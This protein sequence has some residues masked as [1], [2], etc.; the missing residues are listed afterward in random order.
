MPTG[1]RE[2]TP[3]DRELIAAY[4]KKNRAGE[5]ATRA[6]QAAYRRYQ[7]QTEDTSRWQH[8]ATIPRKHWVKLSGRQYATLDHHAGR[9]GVPVQGEII[10]LGAVARWL[11][12]FLARNAG[13]LAAETADPLLNAKDTT[14]PALERYRD[15]K[16][17]LARLD[18]LD[19]EKVLVDRQRSHECWN[20][21][22]ELI[23]R[24][25]QVLQRDYG[26]AAQRILNNA[27]DNADLAVER[28]FAKDPAATAGDISG[29][30]IET[31]DQA[32]NL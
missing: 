4:I 7:K 18:R 8:Y 3:A 2:P 31:T 1:P 32:G 6:E 25:G 10:D 13:K 26:P 21:V 20:L 19:R 28:F 5:K 12:D 16:A 29:E 24:A 22:A 27:I 9:Y 14:S 23:R 17:K 30:I 15:E 11:H